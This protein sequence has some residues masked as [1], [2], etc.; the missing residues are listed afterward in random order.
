MSEAL[1]L[2]VCKRS[3]RC[4]RGR[5]WRRTVQGVADFANEGS[6]NNERG[7]C[8]SLEDGALDG[9]VLGGPLAEGGI[10]AET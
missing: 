6:T 9:E 5:F 1:V 3:L 2:C 10:K 8:L 4:D 7:L